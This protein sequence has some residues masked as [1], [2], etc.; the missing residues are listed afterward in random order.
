MEPTPETLES[1]PQVPGHDGPTRWLSAAG[2]MAALLVLLLHAA[3]G[4]R[5][6]SIDPAGD[7]LSNQLS[8]LAGIT[9][10][11]FLT[12]AP[13]SRRMVY[14]AAF[15][16]AFCGAVFPWLHALAPAGSMAGRMLNALSPIGMALL[17]FGVT[18]ALRVTA[19]ADAARLVRTAVAAE[20]PRS[21]PR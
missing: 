21:R 8:T 1:P 10:A 3:L 20:E 2:A 12:T 14:L 9:V 19:A 6:R 5:F 17:S 18:W 13:E 16:C 11:S 7:L 15:P 4:L